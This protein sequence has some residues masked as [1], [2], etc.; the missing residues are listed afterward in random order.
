MVLTHLKIFGNND[1]ASTSEAQS[2]KPRL[3]RDAKDSSSKEDESELRQQPLP[4]EAI[5]MI[6]EVA[7]RSC[8]SR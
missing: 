8:Q 4:Q 2:G 5:V 7:A 3:L 6:P 1:P